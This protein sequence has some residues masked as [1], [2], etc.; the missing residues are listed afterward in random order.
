M[1][2]SK[3]GNYLL[4]E[5]CTESTDVLD[6]I[7]LADGLLSSWI[8]TPHQPQRVISGFSDIYSFSPMLGMEDLKR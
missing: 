6:V 3:G 2:E 1:K 8:L 7:Y 4:L 5:L